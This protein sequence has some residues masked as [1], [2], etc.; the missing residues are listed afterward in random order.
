M[1]EKLKLNGVYSRESIVRNGYISLN[2]AIERGEW[3]EYMKSR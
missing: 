2:T 3:G 1:P